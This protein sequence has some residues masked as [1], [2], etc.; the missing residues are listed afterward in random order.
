M[1]DIWEL[2]QDLQAFPE[3]KTLWVAYSGGLDS[4]VL[5]HQLAQSEQVRQHY[6]LQ[7]IHVNHGLSQ[8]ADQW[9]QHCQTVCEQLQVPYH[10]RQVHIAHASNVEA[11]ARQA[12][13]Q[14]FRD[15]ID[16]TGCLLTAHQ[17]NDQAETFL[18][19]ILRGA[20]LKGLAGINRQPRRLMIAED[21]T[22]SV[23]HTGDAGLLVFRPLLSYSRPQLTSYAKQQ[24]LQWIEDE[25]NESL[26]FDRNFLRHQ[27]MPH[28]QERWPKAI[29]TISRAAALSAES[30][31]LLDEYVQTDLQHCLNS[32]A[33]LSIQPLLSYSI[34]RQKQVLRAWFEQ[35]Q[36]T[37][38]EQKQLECIIA[39]VL[40]A[41]VDANPKLQWGQVQIRRFQD[42][43]YLLPI[44]IPTTITSELVWDLSQP[45]VLPNDLG[46]LTVESSQESGINLT[47]VTQVTVKFRQGGERIQPYGR[48]GSRPL[49]KLFQEWGVPPWQRE[50]VPLIYVADELVAV[51]GYCV[52]AK[53]YCEQNGYCIQFNNM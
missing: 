24:Q 46:T 23:N 4:H 11:Q 48:I 27:I 52:S 36:V 25:S 6:Q 17:Q 43:L 15:V 12:R 1:H 50:R 20:G 51:V 14:V 21:N 38:P 33:S 30:Q 9:Q 49:K 41:R 26:D 3:V 32:D 22:L 10:S 8:H 5:L 28:L 44:N 31:K 35:R 18:Q 7:A 19:R 40:H 42:R 29:E 39:E 2:L 34:P 16:E 37:M 53:L 45:L 13:Y 47:G